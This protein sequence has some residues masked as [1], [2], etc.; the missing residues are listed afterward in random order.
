M[1]GRLLGHEAWEQ[2]V[3]VGR[4]LPPTEYPIV[5]ITPDHPMFRTQFEV[6][7]LP[8]IPSIQSWRGSGG[9]TSER[10]EDSAMPDSAASST[11][12]ATSWWS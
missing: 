5:D 7:E 4:V 12:T 2:W 1:G 11:S 8:Q 6:K 3:G 9:D 10:G